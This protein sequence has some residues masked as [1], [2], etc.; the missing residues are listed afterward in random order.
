MT[1]WADK[2]PFDYVS[3]LFEHRMKTVFVVTRRTDFKLF[4]YVK[5]VNFIIHKIFPTKGIIKC[6]NN[7]PKGSPTSATS[8]LKVLFV[9]RLFLY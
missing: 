3:L 2:K 5:F 1:A 6:D 9:N 8:L 4:L 7:L